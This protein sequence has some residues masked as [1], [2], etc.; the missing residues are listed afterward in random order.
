LISLKTT[1]RIADVMR[2]VKKSSSMWMHEEVHFAPLKWQDGYAIFTVS[3]T[4]RG[5]VSGYIANQK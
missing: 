3:P 2:D 5:A 1:L 4:V